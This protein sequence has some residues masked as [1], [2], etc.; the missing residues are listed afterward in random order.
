VITVYKSA[1]GG[2]CECKDF[3]EGEWLHVVNPSPSELE[4]LISRWDVPADFLTDPLDYDERARIER[5][6]KNTLILIRTPKR[7]E[8]SSKIPF[9]TLPVGIILTDTAVITITLSESEILQ[10][11]ID[12]KI[13][14]FRTSQKTRFVLQIFYRTALKFLKYLKEIN[15]M[16]SVVEEEVH[17]GMRNEELLKLYNFERSLVFF[18]TSLRTNALMFEK[19]NHS[20][21]M[22]MNE[23]ENDLFSDLMIEN[24]QALEM[25]NV[26]A[27]VMSGMM[28]AF[29]S[30]ISNNVAIVVKFLTVVTILFMIPT[31]VAS[32]YGMNVPLPLQENLY[33][34]PIVMLISM[35]LCVFGIF[36]FWHR[37][38]L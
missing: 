10:E 20:A 25:A 33:A 22:K 11:F 28:S 2:L 23:E 4:A 21:C 30:I 24:R 7:S 5:D 1:E 3:E 15:R 38:M 34:F 35:T 12:G 9:Y 8:R 27:K 13:R 17:G 26:Y 19:F 14:N 31:L 18:T 36:Y 6:E 37:N 32:I 16:T 29:A